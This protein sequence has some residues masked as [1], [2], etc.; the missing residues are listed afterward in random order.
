MKRHV[1]NVFEL[2]LAIIFFFLLRTSAKQTLPPCSQELYQDL[3]AISNAT[4]NDES[5]NTPSTYC[6]S[7]M[8]AANK[9]MEGIFEDE[10]TMIHTIIQDLS[11]SPTFAYDSTF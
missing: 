1:S 9:I 2:C 8:H 5:E 11:L 10:A 6:P 3:V 7:T 4:K